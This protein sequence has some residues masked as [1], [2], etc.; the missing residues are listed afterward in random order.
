M[1]DLVPPVTSSKS[2][3]H[4][5]ERSIDNL[6]NEELVQYLVLTSKIPTVYTGI[7]MPVQ[8][9]TVYIG[10]CCKYVRSTVCTSTLATT[11]WR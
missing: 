10:M 5:V 8:Y 9:C 6:L 3:T 4:L 11:S 7:P 2:G 1:R